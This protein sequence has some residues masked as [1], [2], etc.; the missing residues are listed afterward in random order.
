MRNKNTFPSRLEDWSAEIYVSIIQLVHRR[1]AKKL[2]SEY[3]KDPVVKQHQRI[4]RG[5]SFRDTIEYLRYGRN[6]LTQKDLKVLEGKFGRLNTSIK[7]HAANTLNGQIDKMKTDLKSKKRYAFNLEQALDSPEI[8]GI[9]E[10]YLAD[11]LKL[12][13]MLGNEYMKEIG[14]T[15]FDTFMGGYEIGD[16]IDNFQELKDISE[17]K[18]EFWGRDQLGDVYSEYTQEMQTSAGIERYIWHT[19]GDNHVRGT[20]LKD[21]WDHRQLNGKVFSWDKGAED[22]PNALAKPGAKHPGDDY[23]CRCT[24]EPTTQEESEMEEVE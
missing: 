12:C 16:L 9:R 2:I 8:M 10:S 15:A 11:N 21:E 5:D 14:N 20:K 23:Q 4:I 17:S 1:Y 13:E 22:V 24:A 18:A 7:A 6:A 3:K 19:T